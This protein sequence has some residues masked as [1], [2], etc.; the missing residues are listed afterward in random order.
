MCDTNCVNQAT[1]FWFHRKKHSW[2]YYIVHFVHVKCFCYPLNEKYSYTYEIKCKVDFQFSSAEFTFLQTKYNWLSTHKH[3]KVHFC[4]SYCISHVIGCAQEKNSK[5]NHFGRCTGNQHVKRDEK[6]L[7]HVNLGNSTS[8]YSHFL[9]KQ[10]DK[11]QTHL[12]FYFSV[13]KG[14]LN[15]LLVFLSIPLSSITALSLMSPFLQTPHLSLRKHA[16][17]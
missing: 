8:F 2:T 17:I 11:T 3:I 7:C 5:N 14:L 16:A 15:S 1:F 6:G 13:L 9:L 12:S 4:N 10:M